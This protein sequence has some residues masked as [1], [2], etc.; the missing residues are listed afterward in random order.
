M[1]TIRTRIA[2]WL[3]PDV[4]EHCGVKE[5]ENR[6]NRAYKEQLERLKLEN[7]ALNKR[8][9]DLRT[10]NMMLQMENKEF[11][12]RINNLRPVKRRRQR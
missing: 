4:F 12:Q 1:E 6:Q 7:E 5:K 9:Q 8:L 11:I 2:R 10:H 3:C